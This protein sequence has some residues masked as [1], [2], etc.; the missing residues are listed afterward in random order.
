MPD[1]ARCARAGGTKQA[2]ALL[3][4]KAST[5]FLLSRKLIS[6]GPAWS[7]GATSLI[8]S[9]GATPDASSALV[10][11]AR[12]SSVKGPATVKN[13]GSGMVRSLLG[14]ATTNLGSFLEAVSTNTVSCWISG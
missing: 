6:V 2:P 12:C 13:R 11:A 1:G 3:V 5:Y 14:M 9:D 4:E 10:T 7:S 8:R